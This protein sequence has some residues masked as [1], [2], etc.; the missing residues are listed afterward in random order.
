MC[1][2]QADVRF[3]PIA[4]IASNTVILLTSAAAAWIGILILIDGFPKIVFNSLVAITYAL[5]LIIRLL[6]RLLAFVHVDLLA[7]C[8]CVLLADPLCVGL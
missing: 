2:A 6:C 4:D 7:V 1:S 3:V 5:P 8:L